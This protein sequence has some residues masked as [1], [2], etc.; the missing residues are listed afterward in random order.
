MLAASDT[1]ILS[2]LAGAVFLAALAEQS[3]LVEIQESIKRLQQTGVMVRG[4]IFNDLNINKR[5]YGYGMDYKYG[6]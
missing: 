3:T 6:Q 4:V 5:R 2:P 1:A